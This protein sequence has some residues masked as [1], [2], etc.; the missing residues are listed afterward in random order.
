VTEINLELLL[1][2]ISPGSPCGENLEEDSLF[3][4]LQDEARFIEERQMGDS[5]LP[6]EEPDW[7]TVQSLALQLLERTRDI[8]IAMHLTCALLRTDGING[9]NQGLTLLKAW[10]ENYWDS[11]YP[12]QDAD[13]DYPILRVN[14]L[15]SLN[16]YT[17]VRGPINHIP[18]TQSALGCFSWRDIEIA[19]NKIK[20]AQDEDQHE[21]SVIEAAFD[22]T[23]FDTLKKLA[24]SIK[25]ALDHAQ[26][27]T[28]VVVDKADAVNAPDL[29]G[30]TDLLQRISTYV[31]EKVQQRER[32]EITT[33][34]IESNAATEQTDVNV[35]VANNV[36]KP[37]IHS[38]NDV[39]LAID[40]IC[41]YFD[42]YEPSSP[43]PFLLLRAKKLLTMNFME[44]MRDMTPDAVNQAEDICGLQ[45]DNKD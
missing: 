30:L 41:K 27:I 34:E 36:K 25:Q 10:L 38:R 40:E 23:N 19:N 4:Q 29:S 28:A 12:L 33:N 39:G 32:L 31:S 14:T 17:L 2:E 20:P 3:L 35:A 15:S 44:I 9:L 21:L 43:V 18:L 22:D 45:K 13:D 16:D 26:A 24:Q 5:I 1:N 6:A 37:G 42:Q 11:V 7:K 8:Q